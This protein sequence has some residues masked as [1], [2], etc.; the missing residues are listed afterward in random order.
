MRMM[1]LLFGIFAIFLLA[2][3]GAKEDTFSI[4]IIDNQGDPGQ[5]QDQM[6]QLL[7]EKLGEEGTKIEVAASPIYDRQKLLIEYVAGEHDL[8]IL[9]EE[10]MKTNGSQGGNLPLDEYFDADTFKSG[11]FEGGVFKPVNRDGKEVEDIV[12]ETHLYGIPAA[13]TALFQEL[14]YTSPNLFVTVPP[15]TSNIDEAIKVI[16]AIVE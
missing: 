15:R 13:E 4:F 11:V 6:Q 9:P 1:R 3:C 14:Q 5:I 16:K 10:D 2:G 7:Q 8:F 12:Q